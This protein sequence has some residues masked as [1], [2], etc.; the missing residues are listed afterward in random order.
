MTLSFVF[1]VNLF[2][3]EMRQYCFKRSV[4]LSRVKNYL[5]QI[6][7]EKDIITL[8]PTS[9]CITVGVDEE[10][11]ELFRKYL[12]MNYQFTTSGNQ[13]L[14]KRECLFEVETVRDTSRKKTSAKF[15]SKIHING[16]TTNNSRKS[17]SNLRVME[18]KL[19][20]LFVNDTLVSVSCQITGKLVEIS[21]SLGNKRTSL[22]TT[23]QV[24]KG[25]RIDLGSVVE[26]LSQKS[27]GASISAGVNY[28]KVSGSKKSSVFLTLK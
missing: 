18:S 12:S 9:N 21:I 3:V 25:Q 13:N 11:V 16:N 4:S 8:N 15:G 14:R 24:S 26:D 19:A 7:L 20:Q 17:V 10:R 6:K 27:S 28:S 22:T 2:A 1:S 5:N 23:V